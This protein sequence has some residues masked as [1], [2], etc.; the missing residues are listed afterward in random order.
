[1]KTLVVAL[2]LMV[3]LAIFA[4]ASPTLPEK[5]AKQVLRAKR[6]ERERKAGHRDEPMREYLLY[7]QRLEQR[8]EEQFFEHWWN[9]HC[10]PHCNRNIVNPV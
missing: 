2:I 9:P 1:M 4:D 8:S 7:L 6:S 3:A 5:Q 10:Q